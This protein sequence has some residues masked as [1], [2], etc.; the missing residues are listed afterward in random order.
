MDPTE[1]YF[2][3]IQKYKNDFTAILV[4]AIEEG[5]NRFEE[6]IASGKRLPQIYRWP[7]LSYESNQMPSISRSSEGPVDYISAFGGLLQDTFIT[8]HDIPSSNEL[9]DFIFRSSPLEKRFLP[10]HWEN[11]DDRGRE[12]LRTMDIQRFIKEAIVRYINIHEDLD[13]THDRAYEI[14]IPFIN[15]VFDYHLNIDI[16]IPILFLN[17]DFDNFRINDS[18][19]ISRISDNLHMARYDIKSPQVSVS[20]KVIYCSTHALVLHNWYVVNTISDYDF[21]DLRFPETY[22]IELIDKFFAAI[23]IVTAED[24]GY[25]QLLSLCRDWLSNPVAYLPQVNGATLRS[26]PWWFED[27]YWLQDKVPVISFSESIDIRNAF[28]A[29]RCAEE[30]SINIAERRLNQCM[31]RDN[32]QDAILGATIGLEALLSDDH[33]AITHKLALRIGTL[34]RISPIIQRNPL[35][36]FQD[37]KKIYNYR[38]SI[39]HG[40][41]NAE[42]ARIIRIDNERNI[43]ADSMAVNYLRWILKILLECPEYRKATN[44]DS[45]ALLG[46]LR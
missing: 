25:S 33:E 44:I 39:V 32:E 21:G 31:L 10:K 41:T 13:Y 6:L 46:T 20:D 4:K 19:Y 28:L 23:R 1:E 27:R 15:Y 37:V 16:Y 14:V 26:Y 38:S 2:G 22:P 40:K 7:Q 8:M 45:V 9:V 34:A 42:K 36:A 11:V 29:L 17:F 12:I 5:V 35:D 18:I 3:V 43:Y 24:T 30:N